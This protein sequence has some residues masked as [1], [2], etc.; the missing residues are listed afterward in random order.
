MLFNIASFQMTRNNQHRNANRFKFI[1]FLIYLFAKAC[2]GII[3]DMI[4][5]GYD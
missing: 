5:V 3:L 4:Q 1:H 2:E